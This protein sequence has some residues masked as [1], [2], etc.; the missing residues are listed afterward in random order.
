MDISGKQGINP[1]NKPLHQSEDSRPPPSAPPLEEDSQANWPE[2]Y[3]PS[4]LQGRTNTG[5]AT[6]LHPS[7][8]LKGILKC[9]YFYARAIPFKILRRG[10]AEWKPKI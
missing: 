2:P 10:G 6:P 5:R 9:E 1:Q 7:L 8:P 4:H 3:N